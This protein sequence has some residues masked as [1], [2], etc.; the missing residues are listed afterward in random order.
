ME[1]VF[2]SPTLIENRDGET[3]PHTASIGF[4]AEGI[5]IIRIGCESSPADS[6][7]QRRLSPTFLLPP[8]SP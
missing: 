8:P 3:W 2:I 5:S 6:V 7:V 4:T 1:A